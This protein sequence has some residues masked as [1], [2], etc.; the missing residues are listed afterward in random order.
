MAFLIRRNILFSA[1]ILLTQAAVFLFSACGYQVRA[2]G[3]TIGV[4]IESIAI[5]MMTSTSSQLGFEADFTKIIRDEFISHSRIP[6][7]SSERAHTVLVGHIH[8]IRTSPLAYNFDRQTIG[9]ETPTY[10]TTRSRRLRI[11]LDIKL[12]DKT[13]GHVLWH[14]ENMEEKASF[15][16]GTD[17]LSNRFNQQQALERIA[18]Q[19]AKRIYL[20]TMERF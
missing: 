4:H 16:V 3:D 19:L 17:P 15:K 20:K 9:E 10:E 2:T 5:P 7:V 14:E 12:I 13:K 18:R 8:D 6:L 1:L 11:S